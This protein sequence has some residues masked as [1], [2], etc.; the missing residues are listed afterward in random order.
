MQ[1]WA[2][3]LFVSPAKP[4]VRHGETI[5]LPPDAGPCNLKFQLCSR[6]EVAAKSY[7][8]LEG[9]FLQVEI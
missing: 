2:S 6:R 8:S 4:V 1:N 9:T 3:E 5:C 7:V